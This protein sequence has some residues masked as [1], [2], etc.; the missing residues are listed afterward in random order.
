MK[1][2]SL[3]QP[4]ATLVVIGAKKI[5]TRSFRTKYRGPILIHAGIKMGRD[6]EYLIFSEPFHS[7]LKNLKEL[8]LGKIIGSVTIKEVVE[9]ELICAFPSTASHDLLTEVEK[10]FGD[11]SNGRFAWLLESPHSFKHHIPFIGGVGFTKDFDERFC[12]SCGC[13]QNDCSGCIRDTGKPCYWI[14]DGLC[15]ACFLIEQDGLAI[16]TNALKKWYGR[17]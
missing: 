4:W 6:Q 2:L 3:L 9:T 1:V 10:S 13:T 7:A 5:E 14:G 8:P 12:L 11:Y 16:N 15:S 17:S